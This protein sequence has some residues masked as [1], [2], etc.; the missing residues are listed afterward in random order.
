MTPAEHARDLTL[1]LAAIKPEG[2]DD[3]TNLLVWSFEKAMKD[4]RDRIAETVKCLD[5]T[6][7]NQDK[8]AAYI[9]SLSGTR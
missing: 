6:M 1:R 2:A 3:V 4:E 5:N 9:C 7:M 8:L